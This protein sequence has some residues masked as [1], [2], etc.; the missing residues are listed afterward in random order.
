M[1]ILRILFLTIRGGLKTQK[2]LAL[3]NLALRQQLSVLKAAAKRPRVRTRD[4]VFW[5][6]LSRY[7]KNWEKSLVIVKPETVVRWNRKGFKLL[8]DKGL[9]AQALTGGGCLPG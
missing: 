9:L 7:W 5:V 8:M 6:L 4:R 2:E 1:N 3:E